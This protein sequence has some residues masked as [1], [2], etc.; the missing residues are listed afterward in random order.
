M[1]NIKWGILAPGNIAGKFAKDL[2]LVADGEIAAVGSRSIERAEAFCKD[3][4]NAKAYGSYEAFAEDPDVDVVYIASPHT[5]HY[6]HTLLCLKAGKHVLVEKPFAMDKAE[7]EEMI[8]LAKEKELFLMEAF[9]TRFLPVTER[10]LKDI[11]AGKLGALKY[12]QADFGFNAAFNPNSRLYD[13]NLGGG[14][15]LDVGVY[16]I[17][18]ANLLL[19][20]PNELKAMTTKSP[21]GSDTAT[22]ILMNWESGASAMLSCSV[23]TDTP[24]EALICG[25][26]SLIRIHSRW[27]ESKSFEFRRHFS[28]APEHIAFDDPGKGYKHEII[29]VHN[30]L[31]SG[32]TESNKWSLK[33]TLDQVEILDEI[34]EIIELQYP[35]PLS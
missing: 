16:P 33:H 8:N 11:A 3:Y 24:T 31:K 4:P 23:N 25:S 21:T 28:E 14:A 9:W 2:E 1:T 35:K 7:A 12:I 20:K 17:F 27:H 29:E 5:Y 34:R 10:I 6:Q 32:L 13:M 22:S 30:C 26:S 18:L 15:L 19:G